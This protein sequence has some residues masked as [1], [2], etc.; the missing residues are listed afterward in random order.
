M[1]ALQDAHHHHQI[2]PPSS[3]HPLMILFNNYGLQNLASM[4]ASAPFDPPPPPPDFS[5]GPNMSSPHNLDMRVMDSAVA[6]QH[7]SQ[8]A[9][10][11]ELLCQNSPS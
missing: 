5:P 1:L 11:G 6:L 2:S 4:A 8:S 3:A 10:S 7:N 9:I